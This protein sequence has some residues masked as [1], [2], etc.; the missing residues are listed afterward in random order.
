M[1][2]S[3]AALLI[4]GNEHVDPE[5]LKYTDWGF[6]PETI[7]II[8]AAFYFH[9]IIPQASGA[10]GWKR[11][12][13]MTAITMGIVISIAMNLAWIYAGIGSL[14]LVGG[15]NSL[16]YAY[17]NNLPATVPM[18]REIQSPFFVINSLIFALLA[19]ST[20]YLGFGTALLGFTTDL[21]KNHLKVNNRFFTIALAFVPPLVI[22]IIYP[23]IFL[24][25]LNL[26][27]GLGVALLFGILPSIIVIKKT[28]SIPK[29]IAGFALLLI[30][31]CFVILELGQEFGFLRLQ[32]KAEY[33]TGSKNIS[34]DGPNITIK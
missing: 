12:S 32:P 30:F 14:P 11:R 23:N 27:G 22:S 10:L 16:M 29:K 4:M 8:I 28:R 26:V 9:N 6:A 13:I 25:V 31:V 21:T 19:I 24:T 5:R 1:L 20:S 15:E 18:A 33:W 3:F 34:S 17:Q 7:P 2:I